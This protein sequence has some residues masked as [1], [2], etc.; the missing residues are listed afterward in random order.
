MM[1][2]YNSVDKERSLEC[3]L[4]EKNVKNKLCK[5]LQGRLLKKISLYDWNV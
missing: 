2:S 5:S 1:N 4:E 3:L